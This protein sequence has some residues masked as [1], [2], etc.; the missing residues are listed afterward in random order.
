MTEKAL[1]QATDAQLAEIL[2]AIKDVGVEHY[3]EYISAQG[4]MNVISNSLALGFGVLIFALAALCLFNLA[5]E[6]EEGS[7]FFGAALLGVISF[8]WITVSFDGL[9]MAKVQQQSPKGHI[10]EKII[11]TVRD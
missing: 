11:N 7:L 8:F 9:L 1:L 2:K 5:R 3:A 4:A 6:P 10:A